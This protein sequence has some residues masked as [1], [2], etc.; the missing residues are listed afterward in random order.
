MARTRFSGPVASDHG[1]EMDASSLSAIAAYLAT[2]PVTYAGT[3]RNFATAD[4]NTT[5]NCTS[6]SAITLTVQAGLSSGISGVKF[7]AEIRQSGTGKATVAAGAG[8]TIHNLDSNFSTLARYARI[9][10][11]QVAT[12]EYDLIGQ[13]GA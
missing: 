5:V 13:V 3:A 10:L 11:I 8:V 7:V 9:I 4:H 6:S 12:D 1:F 2:V